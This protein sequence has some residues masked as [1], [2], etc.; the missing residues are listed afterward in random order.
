MGYFS[1]GSEGMDYESRVC[2]G[3]VHF[4]P[5]DG[6]CMVWL[7]HLTMNYKQ[8]DIPEVKEILDLLIPPEKEGLGNQECRMRHASDPDR[9]RDTISLF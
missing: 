8:H 1:N 2:E 5:D 6:G 7:A 9:C 4:K 3:C